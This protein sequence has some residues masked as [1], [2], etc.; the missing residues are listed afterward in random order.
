V[1]VIVHEAI[2][3]AQPMVAFINLVEN[4]EK[5]LSILVIPVNRLL[6]ISP[7]GYMIYGARVFDA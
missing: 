5:V 7:R 2:G 1:E 6:F 3:M 4:G